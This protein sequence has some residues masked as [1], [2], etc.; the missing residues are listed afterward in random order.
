LFIRRPVRI[1][2]INDGIEAIDDVDAKL[3]LPRS[4]A[5]DGQVDVRFRL[6][7]ELVK[8]EN[9]TYCAVVDGRQYLLEA[10]PRKNTLFKFLSQFVK[11]AEEV[12]FKPDDETGGYS[13]PVQ[14]RIHGDAPMREAERLIQ[15]MAQLKLI[16]VQYATADNRSKQPPLPQRRARPRI[17]KDQEKRRVEVHVTRD[18]E[19]VTYK[20]QNVESSAEEFGQ[21]LVDATDED[22]QDFSVRVSYEPDVQWGDVMYVFNAATCARITECGL[23]PLRGQ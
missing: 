20:F 15:T 4:D 8:G 18:G 16:N 2:D 22:K 11:E 10:D 7:V 19:K 5:S 1:G 6:R 23:L 17:Q 12:G 13:I 14:L 9:E 21:K 3:K